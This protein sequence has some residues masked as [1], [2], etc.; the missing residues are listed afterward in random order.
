MTTNDI[1]ASLQSKQHNINDILSIKN[2]H[3]SGDNI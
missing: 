2:M 3:R 1:A